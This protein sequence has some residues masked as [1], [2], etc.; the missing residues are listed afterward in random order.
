[1]LTPIEVLVGSAP[2]DGIVS[3][4]THELH[5]GVKL[6]GV[7]IGSVSNPKPVMDHLVGKRLT[8]MNLRILLFEQVRGH[9][10]NGGSATEKLPLAARKETPGAGPEPSIPSQYWGLQKAIEVLLVDLLKNLVQ[11]F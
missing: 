2:R 3:A 5:F 1:M 10:N 8:N 4:S 6:I 9:F 11:R 7:T